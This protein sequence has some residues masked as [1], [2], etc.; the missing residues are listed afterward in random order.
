MA[1]CAKFGQMAENAQK[2][3]GAVKKASKEK[4]GCSQEKYLAES[5]FSGI[6][7]LR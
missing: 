6:I 4:E 3:K 1:S 5:F 2:E 7:K